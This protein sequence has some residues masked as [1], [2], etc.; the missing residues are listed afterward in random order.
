[1]RSMKSKNILI[2]VI[3][4]FLLVGGVLALHQRPSG[5]ATETADYE[6]LTASINNLIE[7][8]DTDGPEATQ[9]DDL[10]N[11]E[12]FEIDPDNEELGEIY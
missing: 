5:G 6:E 1:M 2:I 3:I 12:P 4:G 7:A 9:P 8:L 11:I 10:L